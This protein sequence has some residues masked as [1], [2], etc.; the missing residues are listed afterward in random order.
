MQGSTQRQTTKN[1]SNN[2]WSLRHIS[3]LR[4]QIAGCEIMTPSA[5][6]RFFR[7]RRSIGLVGTR[8]QRGLSDA[9]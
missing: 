8:S 4:G 6:S 3:R 1:R 7:A 9:A 5:F 2:A